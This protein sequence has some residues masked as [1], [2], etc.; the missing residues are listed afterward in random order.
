MNGWK[1]ILWTLAVVA[2][3]GFIAGLA[4]F[5]YDVFNMTS[6]NWQTVVVGIIGGLGVFATNYL[7]PWVTRYGIGSKGGE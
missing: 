3:W 6:E 1:G 4:T 2:A 5:K 7:A